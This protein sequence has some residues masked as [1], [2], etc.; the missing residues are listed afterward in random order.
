MRQALFASAVLTALATLLGGCAT[1][2]GKGIGGIDYVVV[3]YAEN[4]S[5][6]HLYGLFPGAEGIAQATAGQKTQLDHDGAPLPHLPPTWDH[7]KPSAR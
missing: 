6:D 3:I 2:A 4:R 5:F 1:P 7:G